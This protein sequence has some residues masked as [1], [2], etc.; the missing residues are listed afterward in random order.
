MTEARTGRLLSARPL[1]AVVGPTASGKTELALRLCEALGGEIVGC[2]ALQIRAGLPI[3]TAKPTPM[4]SGRAAH[5]LIG[6]LPI[7]E[8]ATAARYAELADRVIA[9]I[10]ARG[11]LPVLCGGTGLYLRALR[12]GLF[13]GPTA[14]P[15]L[16]AELRR[17]A[18][19]RG[20][21]T[22]HT[23]LA[24]VDPAAAARIGPADYVRIERALEVFRLTGRPISAWQED[25][26]AELRRGPRHR[27]VHLGLDPGTEALRRRI[28]LRAEAML[29]SGLCDEVQDALAVHG[30]LRFPPLGFTEV[31]RHLA[32][33][34][35][36]SALLA[37]LTAKTAQ[38]ARRQRT[39]FRSERAVRWA[40]SLGEVTLD[41]VRD[42]LARA[43]EDAPDS[44]SDGSSDGDG[45]GEVAAERGAERA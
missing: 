43:A 26:R 44:S 35:D 29:A 23:E 27:I 6:T 38:Y 32:G 30:R 7:D 36:E 31:E 17:E 8:P 25:S 39:W 3:L 41:E 19:L 2:D 10:L 34:L 21:A 33:E 45:D 1:V 12:D 40:P 9:D 14:D 4:E 13:A 24:S 20:V 5:H 37:E 15:A 42:A 18:E 28:R 16:R 11:R 22:L